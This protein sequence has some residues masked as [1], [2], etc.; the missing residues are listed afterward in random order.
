M[1]SSLH[2]TVHACCY[3]RSHSIYGRP[4]T[5]R[6]WY[7][8]R[9]AV[10]IPVPERQRG[11]ASRGRTDSEAEE[12][13]T[14]TLSACTCC[15]IGAA[16][17]PPPTCINIALRPWVLCCATRLL[18]ILDLPL[19]CIARVRVY[20]DPVTLRKCSSRAEPGYE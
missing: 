18:L 4:P 19:C 8:R 3:L 1:D 12:H 17:T 7:R 9:A 20:F 5:I 13:K 6:R 14:C 16:A 11:H 2:V 15:A 10:D